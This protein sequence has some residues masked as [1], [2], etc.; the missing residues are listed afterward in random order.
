[1]GKVVRDATLE[2]VGNEMNA[3]LGL[4]AQ[5]MSEDASGKITS[6]SVIRS[7]LRAGLIRKILAVGDL[8][9]VNKE[10]S[11]SVTVAGTITAATV[12]EDT[13]LAKTGHAGAGSYEFSYDGAAWSL[14]GETVEL[15]E[16]GVTPTGT[17]AAED[18]IVVHEAASEI[19]FEVAGIDYDNPV[20]KTA[21]HSLSLITRDVQ[22]YGTIPFHSPQL[23][24]VI[25]ADEFADGL[26]AGTYT[27]TLD[28]G[29]YDGGTTQDGT[30]VLVTMQTIPVGGGIRHSAIG[31][32]QSSSYTK[33]QIL[34]GTWTTYDASGNVI[35]SGLTTTEATAETEG[36]SLGTAT[37]E[38][39]N[40]MVGTHLN[41]TRRQAH[42]SNEAAA[43]Y[44][45]MW[46]NSSAAG[47]AS[48]QTASW[49]R[50]MS[51][52]DLPIKSTLPGWLHGMDP[53]FV[54]CLGAVYKRTAVSAWDNNGTASYVDTQ[55]T[56]FQLSMTEIGL[57]NNGSIVETS[58]KADGTQGSTDPYPLY[59]GATQADRIKY[60]GTTAR[61]WWLRSPNPSSCSSVRNVDPS[62][63]LSS[64]Y[65]SSALGAV[66][67]LNFI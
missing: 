58:P 44:Q 42:G 30:F 29:A 31:V 25:A 18:K 28:H 60:E 34:A 39:M 62:G 32:Y 56:V 43:S 38:S 37:A 6:Y 13:F 9:R 50:K 20:S 55:D 22:S 5:S 10:T 7:Y 2:R 65:A 19:V 21:E 48:G 1:M 4:I 67:G 16:Y 14:H 3:L 41:S 27:L 49:F 33:A 40:L 36:T 53:D 15:S 35:E 59:S 63:A 61:Y 54:D 51:E 66:A 52:F 23:L 12:N 17:P 57:G 11:L 26:P 64:N 8:I 45:K 47:A 24:K 46:L